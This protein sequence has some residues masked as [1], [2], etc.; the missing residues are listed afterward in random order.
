MAR[1]PNYAPDFQIKINGQDLPAAVRSTVTSVSYEDGTQAADRVEVGL[2]NVDLRWLQNHIRGLGFQPYPSGV[3]VGAVGRLDAAPDGTFDIDNKLS[4]AIGYAPDPLE[5]VFVGEV[6]GVEAS[7]PNGGVPTMTLI[8]HDYLN[9]LSQGSYA[10]G[11][12]FLPDAITAAI[13]SAENLLLPIIDPAVIAGST[14]IAVLNI[15]FKGTG[16]KQKGQSDLQLLEE[17]AQQYDADFWVE[18]DV[19]YLSRFIKEYTPRLTLTWGESLLDF[20]P[21]VSLVGQVVGV[22]ARFILREIPLDFLVTVFWDFDR[23]SL[24][25]SVVPGAAAAVAKSLS[26]GIITL[27]DRPIG[28]PADITNSALMLAHELR[29]KL[30]NRLTG[31]GSAIG[32]PR[33]RAGAVIRLEGLGPDFSGDY[34]VSSA[35]HSIDS[36]GYRTNFMVRKE[37]LP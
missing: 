20:S 9:R 32:D 11:F 29:N 33:I 19:L 3:R 21:R 36:G 28:S 22:S 1:H 23:E 18:G 12:G 8:A 5:D 27:I 35:T 4:L 25:I 17:I 31:R 37:I 15:I 10:R 16:R 14:A 30:N 7:F 34:R 13:L 26:G 6:T 2:A 24:G